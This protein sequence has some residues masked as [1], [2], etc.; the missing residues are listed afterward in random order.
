MFIPLLFMAIIT[1]IIVLPVSRSKKILLC[2]IALTFFGILAV[3]SVSTYE[4]F[5][6]TT[7]RIHLF[8]EPSNYFYFNQQ[9]K[10]IL[11]SIV[12][13]IIVYYIPLKF[14]TNKKIILALTAGA[15]IMQI[16]ALFIA[17]PLNGAR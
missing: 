1:G 12:I 15:G 3:Y 16:L 11:I 4:S 13:G 5:R 10:S 2:G 6:L 9:I 14:F 7:T 17:D 8:A